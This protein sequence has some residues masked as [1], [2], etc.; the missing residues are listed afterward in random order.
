MRKDELANLIEAFLTG[1]SGNWDWDDF[2]SVRQP[3]PETEEI[4]RRCANLPLEF[5]PR[6][7]GEYCNEEGMAI[8]KGYIST[9][10]GE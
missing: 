5:P 7:E 3:D 9:L 2:V 6:H 8:L 10:R 1:Q 4:R